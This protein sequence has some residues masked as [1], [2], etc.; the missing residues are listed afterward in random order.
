MKVWNNQ[1]DAL[2]NLYLSEGEVDSSSNARNNF[3]T[4]LYK[5]LIRWIRYILT[6]EKFLPEMKKNELTLDQASFILS[7]EVIM[8]LL[9]VKPVMKSPDAYLFTLVKR[10]AILLLKRY[11]I[12]TIS[13]ED[14]IIVFTEDELLILKNVEKLKLK[15][16]ERFLTKDLE[17]PLSA[18]E[19]KV[20][21]ERYLSYDT[22]HKEWADVADSL[23][24]TI[25]SV[26]SAHQELKKKLNQDEAAYTRLA[27]VL[28][29]NT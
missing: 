7:G 6:V 3:A 20:F 14:N 21:K 11:Q 4:V 8:L 18:Y 24:A 28:G 10:H 29:R 22:G 25:D 5:S 12:S 13:I 26:K 2:W 19:F 16:I 23:G 15:K 1:I 17:T 27:H 9:T